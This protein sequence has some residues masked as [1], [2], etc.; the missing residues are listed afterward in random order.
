[1]QHL[2]FTKDF[3]RLNLMC[4]FLSFSLHFDISLHKKVC[5]V[6]SL[7]SFISLLTRFP[8]WPSVARGAKR[9]TFILSSTFFCSARSSTNNT[10][11]IFFMLFLRVFKSVC[12]LHFPPFYSIL[13]LFFIVAPEKEK[14]GTKVS[15]CIIWIKCIL[16][17]TPITIILLLL[18]C[19]VHSHFS[20]CAFVVCVWVC[21]TVASEL[22]TR[23]G[24][25]GVCHLSFSVSGN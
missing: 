7:L 18:L 14:R 25:A 6:A 16:Q 19:F 10:N 9:E 2:T 15:L 4:F 13:A 5:S 11:N 23:S 20:L 24:I 21:W 12:F 22:L 8:F 17:T 1:M 3:F